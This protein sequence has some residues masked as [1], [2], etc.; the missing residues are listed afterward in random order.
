MTH[1]VVACQRAE[2][3]EQ[4][5]SFIVGSKTIAYGSK[6]FGKKRDCNYTSCLAY[7]NCRMLSFFSTLN[8]IN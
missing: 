4:G 7:R 2:S 8:A 6:S 1:A 3:G 5:S